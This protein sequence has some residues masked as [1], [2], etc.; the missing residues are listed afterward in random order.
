MIGAAGTLPTA[1]LPFMSRVF[2]NGAG[3]GSAGPPV[4][5]SSSKLQAQAETAEAVAATAGVS[6]AVKTPADDGNSSRGPAAGPVVVP[7]LQPTP[8]PLSKPPA[9]L[10]P[11]PSPSQL[12]QP[13][14]GAGAA[15]GGTGVCVA[16]SEVGEEPRRSL[17]GASQ[18][19]DV[20]LAGVIDHTLPPRGSSASMPE[21][22]LLDTAAS[23][24]CR[25]TSTSAESMDSGD[26]PAPTPGS[27][28]PPQ[29]GGHAHTR[30][31]VSS[32]GRPLDDL[33]VSE[34]R[35]ELRRRGLSGMG[36]REDLLLRLVHAG[37]MG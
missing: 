6:K 22:L 25:V 13:Q 34:L 1:L 27:P 31:A 4:L 15:A 8:P 26:D 2:G 11:S 30:Q 16:P 33:A 21:V 9:D 17:T 28:G 35:Y 3:S 37:V 5:F 32:S 36:K 18:I 20:G 10:N 24:S 7:Q 19:L 12:H 23:E 29:D 14:A